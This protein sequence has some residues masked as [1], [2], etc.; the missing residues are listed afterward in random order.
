LRRAA[1]AARRDDRD[2]DEPFAHAATLRDARRRAQQ[3]QVLDV[4]GGPGDRR[5][6]VVA[7]VATDRRFVVLTRAL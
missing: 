7:G 5:L 1:P 6:D 3:Q 4:A 2:P